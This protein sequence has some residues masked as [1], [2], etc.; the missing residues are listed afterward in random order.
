MSTKKNN[1][2]IN[3]TLFIG[4][5][6]SCS[7]CNNCEK[8]VFHV[9]HIVHCASRPRIFRHLGR[10]GVISNRLDISESLVF[11]SV[12]QFD[13]SRTLPTDWSLG[14]PGVWSGKFQSDWPFPHPQKDPA[15]HTCGSLGPTPYGPW[16]LV[17]WQQFPKKYTTLTNNTKRQTK[18]R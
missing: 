13:V 3:I 14:S 16:R 5:K 8:D 2:L 6:F 12:L 15:P 9:V 18:V 1:K 10:S 7:W 11:I 17:H 4:N